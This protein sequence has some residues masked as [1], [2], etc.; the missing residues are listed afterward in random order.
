VVS[1]LVQ[2]GIEVET[3]VS[4]AKLLDTLRA[5]LALRGHQVHVL[6]AGGLLVVWQ[7]C[8]RHCGDVEALEEFARQ[9]G[10]VH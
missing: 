4:P 3:P 6:A 8:S 5:S 7:G 2:V 1:A 9:V 10:A